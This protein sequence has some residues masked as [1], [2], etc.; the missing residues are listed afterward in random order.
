MDPAVKNV[1][2]YPLPQ[3]CMPLEAVYMLSPDG[4]ADL[5]LQLKA[6][7]RGSWRNRFLTVS[8]FS[9]DKDLKF[10][11]IQCFRHKLFNW[12]E[13]SN[14]NLLFSPYE[15]LKLTTIANDYLFSNL[16]AAGLLDII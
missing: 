6:T 12:R 2:N 11:F 7:A 9:Q 15:K 16:G 8:P 1:F 5:E 3:V 10:H 13:Y 14:K 4:A